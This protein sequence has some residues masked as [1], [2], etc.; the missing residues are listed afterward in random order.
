MGTEQ[1]G[2]MFCPEAGVGFPHTGGWP[3]VQAAQKRVAAK[4]LG[5]QAVVRR[6][7]QIAHTA[8]EQA[9]DAEEQHAPQ[10]P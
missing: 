9:T 7:Q 10:C 8:D 3:S 2:T 5:V 1:N 6:L 4:K